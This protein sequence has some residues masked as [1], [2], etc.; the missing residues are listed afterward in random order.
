[1]K[2]EVPLLKES[3]LVKEGQIIN[4]KMAGILFDYSERWCCGTPN[5]FNVEDALEKKLIE[6]I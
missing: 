2:R 3:F 5:A 6:T 1:M 4:E